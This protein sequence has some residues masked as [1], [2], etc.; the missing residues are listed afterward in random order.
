MQY[1]INTYT[2]QQCQLATSPTILRRTIDLPLKKSA[3]ATEFQNDYTRWIICMLLI[4]V[5]WCSNYIAHFSD[6]PLK[7]T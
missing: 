5:N 4:Y 6:S 3:I 1:L 2:L 7:D